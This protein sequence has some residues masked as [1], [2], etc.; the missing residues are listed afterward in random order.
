MIG[1]TVRLTIGVDFHG[2]I[3]DH[4]AGSH[5]ATELHWP[6][7]PGALEWLR[8]ISERFD[9]V[10]VSA[11]FAR[12]EPEGKAG[13]TAAMQ[14]LQMHGAPTHWFYADD[15]GGPPRVR[16]TGLKPACVLWIDDRGYC[17]RGRF[18]SARDVEAFTPWNRGARRGIDV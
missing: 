10:L 17:F 9:V 16:L 8:T 3:V 2:V 4:P 12:P 15:E 6:E 1:R 11:R 5:G 18:P 14:W 7:V 13:I